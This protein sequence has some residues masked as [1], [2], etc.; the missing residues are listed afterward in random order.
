MKID[1]QELT[2]ILQK[3]KANPF[4]IYP[5]LTPHTGRI[6]EFKVN[7]GDRVVGPSGLWLEKPGTP[8][9]VLEREKN[10]KII[11]ATHNGIVQNLRFELLHKFVEA[12]EKILEI[13]HPL[14]QEEIISEILLSSLLVIRA[15]ETARYILS[16]ELSKKIEKEG[17]RKIRVKEG[18]ELLIMTFMKRETPIFLQEPGTFIIYQIYFKPFELVSAG[19]PLIGLCPVED[20]PYLEKIIQRIKEE[21]TL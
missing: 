13:K 19:E 3:F 12:G 18:D 21:W 17:L 1:F 4:K 11:R 14:T 7:E 8:L 2:H 5:L 6:I 10:P 15:S 16:P 9:F 20:L